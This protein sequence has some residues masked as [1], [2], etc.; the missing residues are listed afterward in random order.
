MTPDHGFVP[1]LRPMSEIKSCLGCG[2]I[3]WPPVGKDFADFCD[4]C[5]AKVRNGTCPRRGC[6][7][8]VTMAPKG[9][10]AP[11]PVVCCDEHAFSERH[12]QPPRREPSF[13]NEGG[14]P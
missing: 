11:W 7:G 8:N 10:L 14:A 3:F 4:P 9:D 12:S 13:Y 2:A 1:K 5:F 6:T